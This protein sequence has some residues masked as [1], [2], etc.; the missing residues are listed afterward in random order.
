M[1]GDTA[2]AALLQQRFFTPDALRREAAGVLLGLCSARISDAEIV[3]AF[4]RTVPTMSPEL[5]HEVRAVAAEIG[6]VLA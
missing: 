6:I 4:A 3:A 1:V 5:V 2:I